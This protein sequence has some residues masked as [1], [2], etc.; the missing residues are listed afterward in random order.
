MWIFRRKLIA[1]YKKDL[2]FYGVGINFQE[3]ENSIYQ[4][5]IDTIFSSAH[6]IY[7]RDTFSHNYLKK[8]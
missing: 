6:E 4:K 3:D 8:L 5:K 1:K 7:V 2:V